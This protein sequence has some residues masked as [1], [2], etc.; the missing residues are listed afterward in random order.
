MPEPDDKELAGAAQA[1][2]P[3]PEMSSAANSGTCCTSAARQAAANHVPVS[4]AV[5]PNQ[6]DTAV[7]YVDM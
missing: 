6:I 4:F 5:F 3:P 2:R 7:Q 1:T